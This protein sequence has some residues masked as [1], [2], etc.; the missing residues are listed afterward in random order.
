MHV[1]TEW[2]S[3]IQSPI[4]LHGHTHRLSHLYITL[5][6]FFILLQ[7][8]NVSDKGCL[9]SRGTHDTIYNLFVTYF[10]NETSRSIALF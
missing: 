10:V 1:L 6:L 8:K 5:N 4:T 7:I 3:T 9:V 2:Q